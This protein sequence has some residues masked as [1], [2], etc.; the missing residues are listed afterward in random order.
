MA[1]AAFLKNQK[2]PNLSKGSTDR[3]KIWYNDAFSPSPQH[4]IGQTFENPKWWMA[5]SSRVE[6]SQYLGNGL[7]DVQN[8]AQW[9]ILNLYKP[10]QRLKLREANITNPNR[11][12]TLSVYLETLCPCMINYQYPH[13]SCLPVPARDTRLPCWR[14]CKYVSYAWTAPP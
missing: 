7:T 13:G 4:S 14:C 2:W 11:Q 12:P 6:K 8:L 9:H 3:C 5:V 1:A 10:D